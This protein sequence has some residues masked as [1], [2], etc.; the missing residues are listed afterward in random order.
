MNSFK[1]Y[2]SEALSYSH[3]TS[4]TAIFMSSDNVFIYKSGSVRI[5]SDVIKDKDDVCIYTFPFVVF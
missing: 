5:S 1:V 3:F 2:S 4:L